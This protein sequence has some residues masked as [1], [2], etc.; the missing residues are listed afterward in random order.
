MLVCC[1]LFGWDEMKSRREKEH[2]AQT[3]CTLV[4]YDLGYEKITGKYAFE[5][6]LQKIKAS[7]TQS[8]A[9]NVLKS[10]YKGTKSQTDRI[11]ATHPMHLHYLY[12]WSVDILGND[13]TFPK[14]STQMYL[15]STVDEWPT[16]NFNRDSLRRWSKKNKGKEKWAAFRPLLTD[17]H[18]QTK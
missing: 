16:V 7:I 18:K 12:Q 8:S 1:L 14:I 17:K 2:I 11:S 4:C 9:E 5:R 3:S 15:L 10:S 13:T 6:W